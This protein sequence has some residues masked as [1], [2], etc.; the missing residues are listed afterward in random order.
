[1]RLVTSC[2]VPTSAANIP[3]RKL[4]TLMDI[5]IAIKKDGSIHWVDD[6]SWTQRTI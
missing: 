1:M 5:P 3:P 2:H 6:V 4:D